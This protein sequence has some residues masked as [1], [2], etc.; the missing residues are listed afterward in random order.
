MSATYHINRSRNLTEILDAHG[1]AE[2]SPLDHA[3]FGMWCAYN[4]QMRT[5]AC[6]LF[7]N[8]ITSILDDKLRM[9][10]LLSEF[11]QQNLTLQVFS[12]LSDY[13]H[14]LES[15]GSE[16]F[17][18]LKTTLGA[19]GSGVYMFNNLWELIHKL[20]ELKGSTDSMIIQQGIHD[21]AL[22]DDR[23]FK[24]RTYVLVTNDWQIYS[25]KDSLVVVHKDLY[26]PESSSADVQLSPNCGNTAILLS[27]VPNLSGVTSQIQNI[28]VKT[29]DCLKRKTAVM[30]NTGSYH[31]FGYDFICNANLETFLIEVNGFPNTER[32][33]SIGRSLSQ[34]MMMDLK[35]LIIDPAIFGLNPKSGGFIKLN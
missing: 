35:G 5:A 18:F 11:N 7:D 26:S 16:V 1:W 27:E 13:L 17:C 2:A 24:I 34:R 14:Y 6:Q 9:F 30:T 15:T 25:Y 10:D 19:G 29:I 3:D 8:R 20:L 31:L 32:T 12:E 33:D 21:V 23:K 22:I 28:V 4:T